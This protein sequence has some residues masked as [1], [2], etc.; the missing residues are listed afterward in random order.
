MIIMKGARRF[1]LNVD[2]RYDEWQ[3]T[4]RE[5]VPGRLYPTQH[6][7]RTC[8]S[9]QAAVEALVRKWRVLFPEDAPLAWREPSLTSPSRHSR[10]PRA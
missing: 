9:H 4:L 3:V 8:N 6:L 7:L 5:F 1:E 10:R 2:A